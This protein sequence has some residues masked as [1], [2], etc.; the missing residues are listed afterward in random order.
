MLGATAAGAGGATCQSYRAGE[1]NGNSDAGPEEVLLV[2]QC[3]LGD[4]E[5]AHER[6]KRDQILRQLQAQADCDCHL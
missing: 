2:Q 3:V 5:V 6:C 1:S 4:V